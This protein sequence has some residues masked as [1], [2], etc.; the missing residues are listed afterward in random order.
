MTSYTWTLIFLGRP[1]QRLSKRFLNEVLK[2][3]S[4]NNSKKLL[5]GPCVASTQIHVLVAEWESG[6]LGEEC[7]LAGGD[8]RKRALRVKAWTQT[9][10]AV[11][12]WELEM[13]KGARAAD[14]RPA[15]KHLLWSYSDSWKCCEAQEVQ[16]DGLDSNTS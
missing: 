7:E 5:M 12:L 14:R 8:G 11:Q 6:R 15:V 10:P 16:I 3:P 2:I 4:E 1:S 9:T 13:L